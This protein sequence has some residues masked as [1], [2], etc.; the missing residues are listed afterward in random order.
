MTTDLEM[1]RARL[2]EWRRDPVRMVVDEFHATPDEW[3]ADALRAFADPSIRRIAMKACKGPG[4]TALLAWCIWNFLSCYGDDGS[5]PKGAATSITQDNIDD[6]L[7]PEL[8]KWQARSEW[9]KTAFEWQKTRIV[10]RDHPETWFFSKRTWPRSGDKRRH[11]EHARR[12]PCRFSVLRARRVG[13]DSGNRHGCRGR[14]TLD[15]P[16]GEDHAGR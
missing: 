1:A 6:N 9:F 16:V 12:P 3:Q 4:K 10:A 7:W 11:G 14:R 13:R 15:R 2:V 8:A 5:H